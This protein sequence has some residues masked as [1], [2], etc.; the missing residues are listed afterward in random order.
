MLPMHHKTMSEKLQNH[1]M[2]NSMLP[3]VLVFHLLKPLK[4]PNWHG[5]SP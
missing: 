1:D 5:F 3:I 4:P 2:A